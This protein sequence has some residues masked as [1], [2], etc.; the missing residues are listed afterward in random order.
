MRD[1]KSVHF[2]AA[3]LALT[4]MILISGR[5]QSVAQPAPPTAPPIAVDNAAQT[6]LVF[7]A[8]SDV[9]TSSKISFE[10]TRQLI[11]H[12]WS[13]AGA[14]KVKTPLA[15]PGLA[16]TDYQAQCFAATAAFPDALII[17]PPA[18]QSAQ[19]SYLLGTRNWTEVQFMAVLLHCDNVKTAH[20]VWY[21]KNVHDGIGSINNF[22]L[23]TLAGYFSGINALN[24]KTGASSTTSTTVYASP[25]P[26]A[27]GTV[28]PFTSQSQTMTTSGTNQ[29]AQNAPLVG[30]AILNAF[31]TN[32]PSIGSTTTDRQFTVAVT[33][34]LESLLSELDAEVNKCTAASIDPICGTF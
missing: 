20:I 21:S 19:N 29:N 11:A 31:G 26:A 32:V 10:T 6:L 16:L 18:I 34:A 30:A 24:T 9:P 28:P 22:T 8:V 14:G 15:L 33:K 25:T 1:V 7:A 27:A 3:V 13:N 12:T 17:L 5:D 4:A 23:L 2:L